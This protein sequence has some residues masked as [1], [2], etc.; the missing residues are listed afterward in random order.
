MRVL[1]ALCTLTAVAQARLI[2]FSA[3]EFIRPGDSIDVGFLSEIYIQRVEDVA[4]SLGYHAPA[5]VPQSLGNLIQDI[6]LGSD[7]SNLLSGFNQTITFPDSIPKGP[8]NLRLAC[9][10]LY[11]VFNMPSVTIFEANVTFADATNGPIVSSA[12]VEPGN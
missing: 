10:G 7:K 6:Q 9:L 5:A 3:P 8:A 11:G 4:C 2:G 12:F 1:A